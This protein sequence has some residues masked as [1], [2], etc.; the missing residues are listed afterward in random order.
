MNLESALKHFAPKGM[1]ISDSSRATASE[2]LTGTDVM[3]ALGMCQ[4]KSPLGF[5]AVLA[6]AGISEEDKERAIQHLLAYARENTP[7]LIVKGAGNNLGKCLAILCRLA[8]EEYT[9]SAATTH[10]CPDCQ[11]RGVINGIANVLVHPGCG[12]KTPAKYRIEP[13]ET[14]CV[15]CHGKGK[16]SARCRCNG[17]GRVRDIEQ[18]RIRGC[19]VE[20]DCER[21]SGVGFRRSPASRAFKVISHQLKDLHIRTWTRNW[22]PFLDELVTKLESEENHADLVFK[23]ATRSSSFAE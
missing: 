21:C 14:Q 3:G 5:S 11:G 15:T 10:T 23:K 4:A 8:F 20:K 13:T 9:R 16:M 7:R 12:E 17:S 22:K 2:A 1:N 19:I 18:S 6:K